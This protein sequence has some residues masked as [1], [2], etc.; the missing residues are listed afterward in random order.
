MGR[1]D[2]PSFDSRFDNLLAAEA[3]HHMVPA[4]WR[5]A[6]RLAVRTALC[7]VSQYLLDCNACD[8]V[9][10]WLGDRRPNIGDG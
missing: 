1:L 10:R 7:G 9:V 8:N 6:V 2:E 3:S 4:F 5:R